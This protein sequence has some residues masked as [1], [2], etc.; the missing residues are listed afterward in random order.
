[1]TCCCF[2]LSSC[3]AFFLNASSLPRNEFNSS[4]LANCGGSISGACVPCGFF[5][6]NHLDEFVQYQI[7]VHHEHML[8]VALERAHVGRRCPNKARRACRSCFVTRSKTGLNRTRVCF[9]LKIRRNPIPCLAI[10]GIIDNSAAAV[11]P[12][13]A[14]IEEFTVYRWV[15]WRGNLLVDQLSA[16]QFEQVES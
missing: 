5:I 10:Y 8:E 16:F 11:S 15:Q 13:T 2:A 7:I 9:G 4:R 14:E 12:N 3:I 6:S 1:M